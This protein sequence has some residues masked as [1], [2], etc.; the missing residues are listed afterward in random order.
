MFRTTTAAILAIYALCGPARGEII[1]HAVSWQIPT[2]L[3]PPGPYSTW[4]GELKQYFSVYPYPE[5]GLF[6]ESKMWSN[7]GGFVRLEYWLTAGTGAEFTDPMAAGLQV[8][9]STLFLPELMVCLIEAPGGIL[10]GVVEYYPLI[11]SDG[12]LGYRS[13]NHYGW[14]R[15]HPE[16]L[17][18]TDIAFES[19]PN[20]PITVGQIPAPSLAPVLACGVLLRRPK[21]VGVTN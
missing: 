7:S 10:Q 16:T 17:L 14:I 9:S 11:E 20:T 1:H 5:T 4:Y 19:I 21:R 18:I 15:M 2:P 8:G 3:P 6:T 12:Y 13:G